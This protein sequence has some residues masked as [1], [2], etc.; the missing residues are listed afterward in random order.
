MYFISSFVD[1]WKLAYLDVFS[2]LYIYRFREFSLSCGA[3]T[4]W[5]DGSGIFFAVYPLDLVWFILKIIYNIYMLDIIF[6]SIGV[7]ANF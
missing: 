5:F 6:Q 4:K 1:R 7:I 3:P 2:F